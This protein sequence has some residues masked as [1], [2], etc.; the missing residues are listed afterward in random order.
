MRKKA[1]MSKNLRILPIL[2]ILSFNA[3]L[4]EWWKSPLTWNNQYTTKVWTYW[5]RDSIEMSRYAIISTLLARKYFNS[6]TTEDIPRILD[7]GCG[8]GLLLEYLP[9]RFGQRY[10]GIDFSLTAIELAKK[11]HLHQSKSSGNIRGTNH[12][13]RMRPTFLNTNAETYQGEHGP[14]DVIIFNEVVYYFSLKDVLPRYVSYLSKATTSYIVMSNYLGF[15]SAPENVKLH[16]DVSVHFREHQIDQISLGRTSDG[17]SF[18]V[19]SYRWNP[20]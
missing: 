19:T 4:S 3:V 13:E 2:L 20:R 17:L 15:R 6:S 10:V 11:R 14:F 12:T 9:R 7:V 8:S 18:N 16:E 5:E 1:M